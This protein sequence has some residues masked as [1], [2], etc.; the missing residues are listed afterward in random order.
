MAYR[1]KTDKPY[2]NDK[3]RRPEDGTRKKS[4]FKRETSVYR[5]KE[6]SF[7]IR[8]RQALQILALAVAGS[9]LTSLLLFQS[10]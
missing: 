1:T 2:A 3:N 9:V 8:G 7:R 10:I 4:S 6:E 5:K